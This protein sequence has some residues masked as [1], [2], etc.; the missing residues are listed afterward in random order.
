MY[1][2]LVLIHPDTPATSAALAAEL[3]RFYQRIQAS[4][5]IVKC[6]DSSLELRF[7][8]CVF[9][10]TH[11]RSPHVVEESAEIAEEFGAE[12]GKQDRIAACSSRFDIHSDEDPEMNYFNDFL[13]VIESSQSLGE[14]YA[15]DPNAG[16][17]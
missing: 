2:S 4:P 11:D 6:S 16:I 7:S 9:Y 8:D 12:T 15:F 17:L 13:Y 10:I 3:R 14:V 1:E 5:T